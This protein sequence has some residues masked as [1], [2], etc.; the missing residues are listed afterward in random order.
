M[1]SDSVITGAGS[2]SISSTSSV[3]GGPTSSS[4]ARSMAAIRSSSS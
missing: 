3:G 2:R 1:G 4:N